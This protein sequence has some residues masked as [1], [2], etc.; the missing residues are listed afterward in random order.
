[1]TESMTNAP[2]IVCL[3]SY[4]KGNEFLRE[5][6]RQ[7]CRVQLVTRENALKEDWARDSLDDLV[8]VPDAVHR[9]DDVR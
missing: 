9:D 3:A 1:M 6:K 7:G 8:A 4:F 2:N 5:A